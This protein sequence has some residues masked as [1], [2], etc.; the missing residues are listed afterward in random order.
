MRERDIH[1]QTHH[2]KKDLVELRCL[3]PIQAEAVR[4]LGNY[5][6]GKRSEHRQQ[7][8]FPAVILEL[9]NRT[10]NLSKLRLIT[11]SSLRTDFL[12]NI[13]DIAARRVRCRS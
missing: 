8:D 12:E 4:V 13:L 3:K 1:L 5:I 2:I 11:G 7:A 10:S 9:P 6:I